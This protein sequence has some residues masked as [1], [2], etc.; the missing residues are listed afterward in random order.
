[1]CRTWC[2]MDSHGKKHCRPLALCQKYRVGGGRYFFAKSPAEIWPADLWLCPEWTARDPDKKGSRKNL[3][4]SRQSS[5]YCWTRLPPWFWSNPTAAGIFHCE[6]RPH[7]RAL[8]AQFAM[9]HEWWKLV[10]FLTDGSAQPPAQTDQRR[11]RWL[12]DGKVFVRNCSKKQGFG[13][14]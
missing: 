14:A 6:W 1:M 13:N 9:S 7:P 12:R 2:R 5:A 3:D 11:K 10:P 4:S 8:Y